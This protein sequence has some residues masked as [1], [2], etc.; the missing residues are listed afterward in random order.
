MTEK[1]ELSKKLSKVQID[2]HIDN[3]ANAIMADIGKNMLS[4]E[5]DDIR[6]IMI[7]S[8]RLQ[9]FVHLYLTGLYSTS[10]LAEL[11][12]VHPN[13]ILNWLNRADVKT[14]ILDVQ[15][16]THETIT[17]KI[18]SLSVKAINRVGDLM[19]SPIDQVALSASKDILDRAGHKPQ[20]NIK[21]DKT[22]RTFEE[23]VSSLIDETITD[24]DFEE[25][26][27]E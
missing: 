13:S 25:V 6:S 21:I 22:V 19:S 27:D 5:D 4:D 20:Q 23:K 15:K 8:P 10:K 7:L 3:K 11:F 14:A 9:R 1:E 17:N 2:L 26:D 24:V 12:D 16:I 18:A